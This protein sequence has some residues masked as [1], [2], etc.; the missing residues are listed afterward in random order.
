MANRAT[1][2]LPE[3]EPERSVAYMKLPQ[4][5]PYYPYCPLGRGKVGGFFAETAVLVQYG[6]GLALVEGAVLF[7]P[8]D[9]E[10]RTMADVEAGRFRLRTPE[11]VV[12]RGWLV[13]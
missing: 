3:T 4:D 1:T 12:A 13:D 10:R 9:V 7:V 6:E 5:W 2:F 11:E 8:G